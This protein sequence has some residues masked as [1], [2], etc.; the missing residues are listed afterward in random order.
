VPSE[1]RVHSI[2]L[3][4]HVPAE[5]RATCRDADRQTPFRV[6]CPELVPRVPIVRDRNLYGAIIFPGVRDFY[7][8]T[9]NNGDNGRALH[10]IVGAGDK[11]GVDKWLLSDR[12]N[13]V[14][15][16]LTLVKRATIRGHPMSIYTFPQHPAG[17]PNGGHVAALIGVGS[18]VV[19][20]SLHGYEHQGG[21]VAIAVD[22]LRL[23]Q[24]EP[25][26]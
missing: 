7:M 9:F 19:F 23:A 12:M 18:T 5:V 21:A 17:G 11:Q 13:E 2:R 16:P 1:L 6:I 4:R 20:A 14:K 22:L 26:S 25:G 3:T 15:G 24:T 8:L 10:W